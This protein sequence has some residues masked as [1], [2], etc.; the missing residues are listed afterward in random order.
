MPH[1]ARPTSLEPQRETFR[2]SRVSGWNQGVQT[3]VDQNPVRSDRSWDRSDLSSDRSNP[4]SD[5]SNLSTDRSDPSSDRYGLSGEAAWQRAESAAT[6]PKD[7]KK[8][9]QT[10]IST[11]YG[12]PSTVYSS[13]SR[14]FIRLKALFAAL[15][16]LLAL[17][18]LPFALG[19]STHAAADSSP[20]TH[21]A[22]LDWISD[23]GWMR[24]SGSSLVTSAL[25]APM[26]FFAGTKRL[27]S[28]AGA[29]VIWGTA[30]NWNPGVVEPAATDD[31]IFDY[32][33]ETGT[34]TTLVGLNAASKVA[35][36][37]TFGGSTTNGALPAFELRANSNAVTTARTLT[38]G[39]S[40]QANAGM[41]AVDSSVTGTQSVGTNSGTNGVMTITL[42]TG[43]AGFTVTNS[44]T[45]QVLNLAAKLAEGATAGSTLTLNSSGGVIQLG[46]ANT[47]TGATTTNAG[48]VTCGAANTI[49]SG[50]SLVLNG[51]TFSSGATTGFAQSTGTLTLSNDSTIALG[52]GS[53]SL[54]F[55]ASNGVSW[56]ASKT[57]TVTGWTG[58]YNGT[59]GTAGKIF[60]GS[61]SSGLTAGQLAGIVFFDGTANHAATILTTGE[62]VPLANAGT[63]Q[64]SSATYSDSD[65]RH[66]HRRH[67][68]SSLGAL[69]DQRQLGHSR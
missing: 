10:G 46:G 56:T 37:L 48:T 52:T 67:G 51:G 11:V 68:R 5:R 63:L 35:N 50:S 47:Y 6:H 55:T 19:T 54:T 29:T 39:T 43:V 24:A 8:Y 14:G 60:V 15:A 7:P 18:S 13:S 9:A 65:Y 32:T 1:L 38:L 45:T 57:L 34:K 58:L 28:T 12:L 16:L 25:S 36:S 42:A 41:I 33:N 66:A 44:N 53:H 49:P 4:S 17:C 2:P 20:V 23:R 30:S 61:T 62:V 26:P 40:G 59:F 64:F 22:S 31:V 69:R 21:H 27:S 3:S